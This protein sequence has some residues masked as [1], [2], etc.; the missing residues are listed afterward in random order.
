MLSTAQQFLRL[1]NFKKAWEKVAQKQGCAGID[2]ET[3]ANFSRHCQANLSQLREAVA[4]STYQPLP[5]RQIF[6]PK[7]QT[8]FRELQIPTVRDRIV[9][10]ALLNVLY[11]L[12][13]EKF[14]PASFA[15]RPQISYLDAVA[16][17]ADWR[18]A[19][20]HWVFDA[21]IIDY[22]NNIQH[23]LLLIKTR[24][25]VENL[26]ILCLIKAWLSVGVLTKNGLI[27]PKKGISQGSVIS[28][29]LANIYLNEFD[30]KI[31]KSD[32]KLVRYADDF[33]ILSD[34]Q[35]RLER[36]SS[37]VAYL[38]NL[39]ELELNQDKT[40][41]TNFERG[42]QFL[43]HGFYGQ[44]IFPVDSYRTKKKKQEAFNH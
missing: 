28:P 16:K 43:G 23:N 3:I 5:Y 42:F 35:E 30:W 8:S 7:N 6:I 22:F 12:T 14:S 32:L 41:I 44:G 4:N 21:D 40:R 27:Y 24:K 33:L 1:S 13:E 20:Y 36:A 29:I 38:L 10:Q 39:I 31:S 15:Y 34:S 25:Y 11:P 18:E 2:N 17:V 9:Q 19:G 37:Q 26:G